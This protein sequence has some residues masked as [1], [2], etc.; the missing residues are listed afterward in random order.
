MNNVAVILFLSYCCSIVNSDEAYCCCCERSGFYELSREWLHK[1]ECRSPK[2]CCNI[3]SKY[4]C[5]LDLN[6]TYDG[7]CGHMNEKYYQQQNGGPDPIVIPR[8]GYG[9]N[10]DIYG[11]FGQRLI[12]NQG[13]EVQEWCIDNDENDSFFLFR[14]VNCNG[15][16]PHWFGR[17]SFPAATNTLFY[18]QCDADSSDDFTST[19][20]TC[21]GQIQHSNIGLGYDEGRDIDYRYIVPTETESIWCSQQN[22]PTVTICAYKYI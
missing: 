19:I 12:D 10:Y 15:S 21:F 16:Y 5:Q 6:P 8:N 7:S 11:W 9:D 2:I 4:E 18:K 3:P 14:F 17:C 22:K 20:P 1:S 13:N